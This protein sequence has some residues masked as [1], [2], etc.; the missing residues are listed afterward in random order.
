MLSFVV[1]L[2]ALLGG[3]ALA[4]LAPAQWR[5]RAAAA[6]SFGLAACVVITLVAMATG[7]PH[8]A[9]L[10]FMGGMIAT[11]MLLGGAYEAQARRR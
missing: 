6:A 7:N 11:A 5:R 8:V 1:W 9:A 2:A 3:L 4:M 10:A